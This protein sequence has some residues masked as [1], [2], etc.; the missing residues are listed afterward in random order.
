MYPSSNPIVCISAIP[1]KM[2]AALAREAI[3]NPDSIT[4]VRQLRDKKG[5]KFE[6]DLNDASAATQSKSTIVISSTV[7]SQKTC[8]A[9]AFRIPVNIYYSSRSGAASLW[10]PM[11]IVPM[12]LVFDDDCTVKDG[13][14]Q[15]W[16]RLDDNT[17]SPVLSLTVPVVLC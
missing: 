4:A 11:P 9:Q 3:N 5:I 13:T 10:F 16:K 2:A 17:S 7:V 12:L 15:F 14:T 8:P 6:A 1:S